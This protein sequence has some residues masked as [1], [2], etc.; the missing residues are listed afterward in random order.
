MSKQKPAV[1]PELTR[2][3][4]SRRARDERARR[5]ILYGTIA[6]VGLV[7]LVLAWGLIN[8]FV[9]APNK[10]IAVVNGVTITQRDYDK[11]LRY[12]QW[13]FE[14]YLAELQQQRA[15]YQNDP[16][17]DFMVQLIDQQISSIEGQLGTLPTT[18]T[19]ELIT[20]E[21]IR[22]EAARRGLTAS[23]EDVQYSLEQQLG[24]TSVTPTPSP[25]S[26]P[27]ATATPTPE[28]TAE[29]SPTPVATAEPLPTATVMT[30]EQFDQ[31]LSNWLRSLK[32]GADF[33]EADLRRLIETA[34]LRSRL[35]TAIGDEV[36]TSTEQVHAQ[37][38]LVA[39][40]EEAD[41]VLKRLQAGEDF[42]TVAKEVSA[43][44]GSKEE[45]GD[46]GWFARGQMLPEFEQAAFSTAPGTLSPVV[47]TQ[48]GF[49]I[50][51]VL[52]HDQ[53]R[54]LSP[55]ALARA[56]SAAFNTWLQVQM[57]APTIKRY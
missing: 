19:E 3:Q 33:S 13:D 11:R 42:A 55:D 43:D 35:Q 39:T 38:I 41:A 51:K 47:M 1:K 36:P 40:P 10:P 46:L 9:V 27:P 18:I 4:L 8:Q 17:Q 28:A 23:P 16:D 34:L 15:V 49:H 7:V 20:D 12:R 45:G 30:K 32:Q 57:A 22:Q 52:G 25:T 29:A 50:I 6:V 53:S 48:A 24:Y 37:H 31:L 2:K 14:S 26:A 54:E 44:P 56:K 21:V 5:Y